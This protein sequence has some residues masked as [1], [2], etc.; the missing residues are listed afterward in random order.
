MLIV[1]VVVVCGR[2]AIGAQSTASDRDTADERKVRRSDGLTLVDDRQVPA[3]AGSAPVPLP[4]VD[5]QALLRDVV[6][7][8]T[9]HGEVV[10]VETDNGPVE[11]TPAE[12]VHSLAVTKAQVKHGGIV[13]R[14]LNISRPGSFIWI[15]VGLGGQVM[16]TFRMLL[17]WWASEK[18]KRVVVPVG[19]WWGSLFGGAMLFAYFCWRK[20]VVGIIGQSTGVFIYA[21]NLVLIYRG[22]KIE[23]EGARTVDT[24]DDTDNDTNVVSMRAT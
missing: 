6:V 20:D 12:Y 5:L 23:A 16:F 7:K 8:S 21:R 2:P 14:W 19:F 24:N 4:R 3:A 15:A 1:L 13:Y 9:P 22:K 11:L 10:R 18:H 17:Q